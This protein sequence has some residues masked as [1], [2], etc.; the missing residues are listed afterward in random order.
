MFF[1]DLSLFI[2]GVVEFEYETSSEFARL[3]FDEGVCKLEIGVVEW[4]TYSPELLAGKLLPV[5]KFI[6]N[7][8]T[9]KNL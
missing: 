7:L 2:R 6:K 1:R 9:I 4:T 5:N 3:Q 8:K